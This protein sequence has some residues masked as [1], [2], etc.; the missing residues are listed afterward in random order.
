MEYLLAFRGLAHDP[1]RVLAAVY[2]FAGMC[3]ELLCDVE[4]SGR[5]YDTARSF[6]RFVAADT[7]AQKSAVRIVLYDPE[8]TLRH[9]LVSHGTEFGATPVEIKP[10]HY[11]GKPPHR[12]C[13][14]EKVHPILNKI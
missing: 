10:H 5:S 7:C 2:R 11:R 8:L 3:V 12:A 14:G 13:S 9:A 4:L 6:K 1:Q